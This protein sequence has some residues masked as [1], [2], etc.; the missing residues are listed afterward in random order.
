MIVST[1]PYF[2]LYHDG[3]IRKTLYDYNPNSTKEQENFI[4]LTNAEMQKKHP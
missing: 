4:H 2:V 1:K 3:F